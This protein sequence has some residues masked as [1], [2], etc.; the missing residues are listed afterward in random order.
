VFINQFPTYTVIYGAL[1]ALPLFLLWVYLSWLIT[2]IGA[3]L[4]AALPV[5][6]YERWWHVATPGSEFVDAMALLRVLHGARTHG[7][8]AAVDATDIRT[9]TRQGFDE[10]ESLLEKMLDA[11]WV[12]RIKA[13]IPQRAQLGKRITTG[14][15]AWVLVVNPE[16]LKV[17]DV[18]R[19]FAFNAGGDATLVR[20]VEEVIEQGL[21]QSLAAHFGRNAKMKPAPSAFAN[22]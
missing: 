11:G 2:L 8:N 7:M 21:D 14:I 19:M 9:Q 12:A 15:D 1:A 22:T 6:K 17:S 13:S 3:V 5:V 4:V 16:Q 18:Y 10:S 20:Q